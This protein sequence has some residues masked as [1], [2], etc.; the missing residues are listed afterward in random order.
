M[1]KYSF[2]FLTLFL[3][4]PCMAQMPKLVINSQSECAELRYWPLNGKQLAFYNLGETVKI[5]PGEVTEL[6][7]PQSETIY[8]IQADK[9]V[10]KFY[11]TAGSINTIT[12]YKDTI[13]FEGENKQYNT[14]LMKASKSDSYCWKYSRRRDHELRNVANIS[15]FKKI[16]DKRK[17][18]DNDLLNNNMLSA[19][20]IKEQQLLTNLRYH[21]LFLKKLMTLYKSPELNEEWLNEFHN[22]EFHF[23]NGLSRQSEFFNEIIKDYTC[24]QAFVV[25]TIS[26]QSIMNSFNTFLFDNYC[27]YLS[28]ENLEYALVSLIYDDIFQEEYSEEIPLLYNRFIDLF[29]DNLYTNIIYPG[30]KKI[31]DIYNQ[32]GDNSRIRIVDYETVPETF[33]EMM[34]PF[35]GKTV[36]VDVWSTTCAPCHKMFS[37]VSKMKEDIGNAENIIYFYISLDND[38]NHDKWCKMISYYNLE[39]YHHRVNRQTSKLI[40]DHLGN[41][42][43]ILAIPYYA[44][45]DKDG[46]IVVTDAAAPDEPEKVIEQL[47][48]IR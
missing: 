13:I 34:K 14:Y 17:K 5:N 3:P 42:N 29:P 19:N 7:L 20:F 8:N 15:E 4:F 35:A 12:I 36:Y 38:R 11:A 31:Q 9:Q 10:F 1:K 26:P 43:G 48:L 45:V 23:D 24:I 37:Y 28:G 46:N 41:S 40:Y 32:R 16:I 47:K 44:I 39:G 27:K 2:I 18:A 30:I 21:S 6:V 25:D 22:T 33:E